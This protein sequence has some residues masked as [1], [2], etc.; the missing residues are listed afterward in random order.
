M[1][2]GTLFRSKEGLLARP[3]HRK[4]IY[5]SKFGEQRDNSL[6]RMQ[7]PDEQTVKLLMGKAGGK[8]GLGGYRQ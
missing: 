4:I 8:A 2:D 6:A 7:L 3:K 5:V 1:F